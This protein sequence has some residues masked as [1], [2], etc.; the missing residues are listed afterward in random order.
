MSAL[1]AKPRGK[2]ETDGTASFW[3]TRMGIRPG[4]P[5]IFPCF[6]PY[7]PLASQSPSGQPLETAIVAVVR[8]TILEGLKSHSRRKKTSLELLAST[9]AWTIYGAAKEWLRTP[10]RVSV[11]QIAGTIEG[12]V[13]PIFAAAGIVDGLIRRPSRTRP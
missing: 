9:A 12:M 1:A 13:A 3:A 10:N 2:I 8:A 11:D 6:S 5:R 4:C 7:F